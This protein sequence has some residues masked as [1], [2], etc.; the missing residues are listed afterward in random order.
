MEEAEILCLKIGVLVNGK[1]VAFGSSEQLKHEHGRYFELIIGIP[2]AA[3]DEKIEQ[4]K[5]SIENIFQDFH[6]K[7]LH[8]VN[9]F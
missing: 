8:A 1:F 4:I 9:I 2:T 3:S 6:Y 7:S 5:K